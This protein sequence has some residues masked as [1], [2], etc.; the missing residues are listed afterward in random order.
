MKGAGVRACFSFVEREKANTVLQLMWID[1]A[2]DFPTVPDDVLAC[3]AGS[4]ATDYCQIW[5]GWDDALKTKLEADTACKFAFV[6]DVKGYLKS[7][8]PANAKGFTTGFQPMIWV[9]KKTIK[10]GQMKKCA[11][12]FQAGTDM[13]YDAAPA[14]LSVAE[15][16]EADGTEFM[17]AL[18]VF[19]D[20]NSGFKAHFPVP[21]CILL[22]MVW[23]VIPTWGK[24]PIAYGFSTQESID[25]AINSNP[26]N[27][28]YKQYIYDSGII[29]PKPDFGKGFTTV[30]GGAAPTEMER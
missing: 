9:A 5:G 30:K 17:W 3:Y 29:G 14:A 21:S 18:R 23:N 15:Y 4:P 27:K 6:R 25:A 16:P 24:V 11:H 19:N 10:P 13:M 2:A 28:Q 22:R 7:P 8:T 1:S 20:Y 26:G 12:N